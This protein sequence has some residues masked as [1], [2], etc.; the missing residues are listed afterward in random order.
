M[1][2]RRLNV[3]RRDALASSLALGVMAAWPHIVRSSVPKFAAYP[4]SLGVSSGFPTDRSVV[5]WTRLAPDPLAADGFGGVPPE[6]I[7]LRWELATDEKFRR[8]DRRG[9]VRA[10]TASAHSV[11]V[12]A[13]HLQPARDYWY[14]F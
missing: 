11:R 13:D 10:N 8:I 2:R 9:E 3:S 1:S 14:R 6:E 12:V 4:F 5:L 7:P